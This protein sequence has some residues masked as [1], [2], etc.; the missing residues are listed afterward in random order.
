MINALLA[1]AGNVANEP[2][3]PEPVRWPVVLL[4]IITVMFVAAAVIGPIVRANM[5]EEAPSTHSH[6]EP[7]GASHHHG[8]GGTHAHEPQTHG[9]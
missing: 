2:I 9:H 7:P 6:D 4:I 1:V 3:L 8:P 5:P